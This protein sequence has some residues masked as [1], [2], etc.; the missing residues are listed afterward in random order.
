MRHPSLAWLLVAAAWLS[1]L[2]A[3]VRAQRQLAPLE[4]A[5]VPASRNDFVIA[6]ADLD[7]DGR[8]DLIGGTGI[9]IRLWFANGPARWREP[10]SIDPPPN[11]GE[12]ATLIADFD[13]DGDLDLLALETGRLLVNDGRGAFV[14]LQVT[15][16]LA[17][18]GVLA[19]ASGDADGDGDLDVL[20]SSYRDLRLLL[21]SAPLQFT[22]A[23]AAVLPMPREP[24]R[25]VAVADIDRDGDQELLALRGAPPSIYVRA[26]SGAFVDEGALRLPALAID[27]IEFAVA[28]LDADGAAEIVLVAADAQDELLRNDGTGHFRLASATTWPR[29]TTTSRAVATADLEGDGDLDLVFS[30]YGGLR[31]WVNDGVGAFTDRSQRVPAV[32]F[33]M[34]VAAFGDLDGDGDADLAGNAYGP[35][36][37]FLQDARGDFV[38]IAVPRLPA[39]LA[40][41]ARIV[42]GD[43]DRDGDPDLAFTARA[44]GLR[45]LHNDG[46]GRFLDVTATAIP[47]GIDGGAS[48]VVLDADRDGILDLFAASS[49]REVLL[50][51]D[52]RGGFRVGPGSALAEAVVPLLALGRDVLASDSRGL[53]YL[54]NDSA[55]RFVDV[56][57]MRMPAITGRIADVKRIDIN[58]DSRPDLLVAASSVHVLVARRDGSYVDQTAARWPSGIVAERFAVADFDGDGDDDV[59]VTGLIGGPTETLVL[60]ADRRGR[61]RPGATLAS[62]TQDLAVADFDD[63]GDPDLY[64]VNRLA[65]DQLFE[66]DG[67]G[68]FRDVSATRI[69][70]PDTLAAQHGALVVDVD[71]DQDPDLVLAVGDVRYEQ[72]EL[73]L[74]N[75]RGLHAPY[76]AQPGADFELRVLARPG[77]ATRDALAIGF[78]ALARAPCAMS[79]IGLWQLDPQGTLPVFATP[80][81]APAGIAVVTMPIPNLPALAG[82]VL[83]AQAAIV[84]WP[85][86]VRFTGLVIARV[87]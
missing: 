74:C 70:E 42:A 46:S 17:G 31:L 1:Q 15:T 38:D 20:V 87:L 86:R 52:G 77:Y 71:L 30:D 64:L 22:D 41:T 60:L 53:R 59:A 58:R 18:V 81:A 2:G 57:S 49:P 25:A 40:E 47:T 84:E 36:P 50:L 16:P 29:E 11:A 68:A 3:G 78:L 82:R 67:R 79:P 9:E 5:H 14:G 7:G 75:H 69:E 66:N 83:F 51:G 28:D 48:L 33:G 85:L 4:P 26:A 63:D 21:Q 27:A 13:A 54:E 73:R 24:A 12:S 80:V 6:A 39:F 34:L 45:C 76:A 62:P 55:G 19:A 65:S 37:I 35:P 8:P 32:R 61:L 23:S 44:E 56:T 72:N 43:F 10:V